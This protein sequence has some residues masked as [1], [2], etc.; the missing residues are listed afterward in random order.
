MS[1][2]PQKPMALQY[3]EAHKNEKRETAKEYVDLSRQI[4]MKSIHINQKKES[5]DRL[6]EYVTLEQEKLEEAR[7]FLQQD[8]EQFH[9]VL[10]DSEKAVKQIREEVKIK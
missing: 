3:M 8:R 4:L 1:G 9:K 2:K 10:E 7:K 6:R 5:C